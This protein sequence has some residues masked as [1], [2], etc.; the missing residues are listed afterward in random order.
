MKYKLDTPYPPIKVNCPHEEYG[1]MILDNVGGMVS[2]MSAVSSYMYNHIIAGEAFK[3][4]KEV[5]LHI[6]M[7]EMEHLQIFSNL[8]LQLGMD[9]RLWSCNH[10]RTEYWSPSFTNYPNQLNALLVN[11]ITSEQKVI[12]KYSFQASVIKDPYIVAVLNRIIM[13]EKLHVE[14]LEGFYKKL[15]RK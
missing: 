2:E 8:A 5:F 10:D 13:D 9:P 11:A 4:L 7:V 14:I 3:E 12:E 15:V 1:Q 6:S